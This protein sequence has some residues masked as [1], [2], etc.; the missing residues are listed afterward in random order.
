MIGDQQDMAARLRAVLP[1]HW[2]PDVA[3]VLD[4]LLNGLGT[5][6][7]YIYDLL[8]YVKA[9]TRISTASDIW[10]DVIALDFFGSRIIRQSNQSDDSFR[11]T[12]I[13]EIFRERGTRAAI[14]SALYDLT[15]RSPLIFEPART[16]DTGGYASLNGLGGGIAYGVAGG[17]GNLDLPFQC[18]VTAFRPAASGIATVGGWCSPAGG[19]GLGTIEYGDLH[20]IQGQVTDGSIYQA[21]ANVL[22]IAAIG[23]TNIVN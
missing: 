6:W 20:M 22:P 1:T 14:V 10:L 7:S 2:F 15:G 9:Q 13:R 5:G 8:Q 4:G 3:P 17:W 12:I 16:T 11:I 18:F 21:V 19:Y 23:W